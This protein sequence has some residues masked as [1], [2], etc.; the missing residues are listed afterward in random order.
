MNLSEMLR[1]Y[2][3]A[4]VVAATEVVATGIAAKSALEG[5]PMPV[6]NLLELYGLM[7]FYV[8]MSAAVVAPG[9]LFLV[10]SF[11]AEKSQF[12]Q[13]PEFPQTPSLK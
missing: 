6:R 13:S 4:A 8:G 5:N 7:T 11:K 1:K 2:P 3:G 12:P 10:D 9:V